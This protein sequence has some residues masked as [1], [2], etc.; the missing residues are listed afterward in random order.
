MVNLILRDR[1]INLRGIL[2]DS[3]YNIHYI[4]ETSFLSEE[5]SHS[6]RSHPVMTLKVVKII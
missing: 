2:I 3:S 4:D 1:G 6:H 5:R